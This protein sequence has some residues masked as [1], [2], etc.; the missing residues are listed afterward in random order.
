MMHENQM[1]NLL[2]TDK[3]GMEYNSV[4]SK[5][6]IWTSLEGTGAVHGKSNG[7]D[8]LDKQRCCDNLWNLLFGTAAEGP[9][10]CNWAGL[11]DVAKTT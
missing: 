8:H 7:P 4:E 6:N 1:N 10:S 11:K 2:E 9:G 5:T 3:N